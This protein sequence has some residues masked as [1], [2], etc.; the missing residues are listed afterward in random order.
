MRLLAAGLLLSRL[1]SVRAHHHVALGCRLGVPGRLL[2]V[3]D[4]RDHL[5]RALI[6][7]SVRDDVVSSVSLDLLLRSGG[8]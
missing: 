6:G 8:S 7:R 2:M 3:L 1:G 5:L 4:G